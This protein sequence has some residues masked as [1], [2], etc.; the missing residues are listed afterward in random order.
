[1]RVWIARPG[2]AHD[3]V[4]SRSGTKFSKSRRLWFPCARSCSDPAALAASPH[5]VPRN[6]MAAQGYREYLNQMEDV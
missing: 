6:E 3:D 2:D 4:T 5:F 1:M